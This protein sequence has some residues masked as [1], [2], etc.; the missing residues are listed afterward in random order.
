MAKRSKKKARIPRSRSQR[1]QRP[2]QTIAEPV[3]PHDHDEVAQNGPDADHEPTNG[4]GPP[5]DDDGQRPGPDPAVDPQINEALEEN[6]LAKFLK[7]LTQRGLGFWIPTILIIAGIVGGVYFINRPGGLDQANA[8]AWDRYIYLDNFDTTNDL[9]SL[10]EAEDGTETTL[11]AQWASYRDAVE[12]FN[13]AVSELP[14]RDETGQIVSNRDEFERLIRGNNRTLEAIVEDLEGLESQVESGGRLERLIL[15]TL[16]RVQETRNKLDDAIAL[17]DQVQENED[18]AE[19][20]EA[21]LAL[22]ARQRLEDQLVLPQDQQFYNR[23]R[24]YEVYGIASA[25]TE[26]ETETD[27]TTSMNDPPS[28]LGGLQDLVRPIE[29]S[30]PNAPQGDSN[31]D[32]AQLDRD[33]PSDNPFAPLQIEPLDEPSDA[34]NDPGD[35][36]ASEPEDIPS[37]EAP[38]DENEPNG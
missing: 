1:S 32:P 8:N 2:E 22:E 24:D 6:E 36:S 3:D 10:A 17:Y 26:P 15:F 9:R 19:T 25:E 13:R 34:S 31:R 7:G 12:R 4:D 27:T 21:N 14:P 29:P 35:P 18:W 11:A 16:A 5:H 38:G 37:T 30:I 33:F 23:I 28:T 20:R